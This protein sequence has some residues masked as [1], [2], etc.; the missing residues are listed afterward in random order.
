[1]VG[2]KDEV[3]IMMKNAIDVV[4]GGLSYWLF[5]YAFSFG[6][7]E[8][9]TNGFSGWGGF[10]LIRPQDGDGGSMYAHFFFQSSFATTAT[11]IVSGTCTIGQVHH[12]RYVHKR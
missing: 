10:L 11:T 5:G 4:V 3:N 8:G 6:E 1:M 2:R 9:Y 7:T 12:V